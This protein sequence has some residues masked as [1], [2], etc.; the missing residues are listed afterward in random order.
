MVVSGLNP[1]AAAFQAGYRAPNRMTCWRLMHDPKV[2]AE[3]NNLT[4]LRIIRAA[5]TS[6]P[7]GAVPDERYP[8]NRD[9]ANYARDLRCAAMPLTI[10]QMRRASEAGDLPADVAAQVLVDFAEYVRGEGGITLDHAFGLNGPSGCDPWFV[11]LARERCR[12]ALR[13]TAP[14]CFVHAVRSPIGPTRCARGSS[15]TAR[16]GCSRPAPFGDDVDRP[17][18]PADVCRVSRGRWRDS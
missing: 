11:K 2:R 5:M 3:M 12:T 10:D 15:D 17:N 14:I 18:R 7:S 13:T 8:P 9:R 4:L 16:P 1:L 6:L